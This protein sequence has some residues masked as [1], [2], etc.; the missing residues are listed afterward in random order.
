MV[1]EA[2]RKYLLNN[3]ARPIFES[4][5]ILPKAN[6]T[7]RSFILAT[8]QPRQAT[9]GTRR[10]YDIT[11]T[12]WWRNKATVT[13]QNSTTP[14]YEL[15]LAFV[16][17]DIQKKP[18]EHSVIV[19]KPSS[20]DVSTESSVLGIADLHYSTISKPIH[21]CLGDP[22]SAPSD[23]VWEC[24]QV[25]EKFMT[26]N[27][28]LSIDLGGDLGRK[29]FDWRRTHDLDGIGTMRKKLDFYN[30]KMVERETGTVVGTFIHNTWPGKKRGVLVV[31][32]FD[33]GKNWE[34][35]VLLS[36]MAVVEYLRKLGG[37]SW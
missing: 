36:G 13:E 35:I 11:A 22:D 28:E 30:V 20:P 1:D 37:M 23:A 12:N 10:E 21:I 19:R 14:V 18:G 32:E 4:K 3:S 6:Q 2:E 17:G 31:E 33:G 7:Q 24:L 16:K 15:D 8:L 25:R 29:I 9:M 26:N 27:F 34:T 5:H